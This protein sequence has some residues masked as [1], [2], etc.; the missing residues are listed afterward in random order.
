MEK[1]PELTSTSTVQSPS[2]QSLLLGIV[3]ILYPCKYSILEPGILKLSVVSVS[4][5]VDI[6]LSNSESA[7]LKSEF[8]VFHI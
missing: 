5:P 8:A 1:E 4:V 7:L 2:S 6:S 3:D